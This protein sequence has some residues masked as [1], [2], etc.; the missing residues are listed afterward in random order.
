MGQLLEANDQV[1]RVLADS[2]V[3]LSWEVQLSLG[4]H[5]WLDVDDLRSYC[6][7]LSHAVA[8]EFDPFK[9][10]FLFASEVKLF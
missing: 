8:H 6:H 10:Q 1:A 5:A 3:S 4:T 7:L 2:L 9:A